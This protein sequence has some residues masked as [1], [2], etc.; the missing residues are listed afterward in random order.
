MFDQVM[1]GW[2]VT[3][4][5]TEAAD[6]RPLAIPGAYTAELS[7]GAPPPPPTDRPHAVAV[8][9]DLF[10]HNPQ[11]HKGALATFTSGRSDLM[12]WGRSQ[13]GELS[14]V[15]APVDYAP[16]LAARAFKARALS[17]AGSN[18]PPEPV[19]IL[20]TKPPAPSRRRTRGPSRRTGPPDLPH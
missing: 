15:T 3:V 16:S 19:E 9:I 6:P 14:A 7:C 5:L 20:Y 12:F 8:A 2:N 10:E 11:I 13:P 18:H 1:A 17:A 4:F